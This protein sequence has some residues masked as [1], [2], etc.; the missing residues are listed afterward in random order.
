MSY[1]YD[2]P[3]SLDTIINL[4]HSARGD[5]ANFSI[6]DNILPQISRTTKY[7]LLNVS[8]IID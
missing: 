4:V 1:G 2:Q 3:D 6:I 5:Y 8:I 7:W